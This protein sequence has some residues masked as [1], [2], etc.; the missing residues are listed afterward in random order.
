MSKIKRLSLIAALLSSLFFLTGC[1]SF[2]SNCEEVLGGSYSSD[3]STQYTYAYS[4]AKGKFDWVFVTTTVRTCV[5]DGKV[6]NQ[7]V[8]TS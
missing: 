6:I 7:D 3:S 4:P 2:Q 1:E 8:S 5:K